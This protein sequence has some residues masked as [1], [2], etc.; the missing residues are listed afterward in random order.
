MGPKTFVL[1]ATTGIP[2]FRCVFPK[3]RMEENPPNGSELNREAGV[4]AGRPHS[5]IFDRFVQ[6]DPRGKTHS[7]IHVDEFITS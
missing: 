5:L 3:Y 7:D 1:R 6:G 2:N 4:L